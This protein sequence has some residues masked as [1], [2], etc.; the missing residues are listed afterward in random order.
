MSEIADWAACQHLWS[1]RR[2][3][4][5]PRTW[6]VYRL[7]REHVGALLTGSP[8]AMDTPV[9][10][11]SDIRHGRQACVV[12]DNII[13]QIRAHFDGIG[14]HMTGYYEREHR[15]FESVLGFTDDAVTIA[16][17]GMY[18][19]L[20]D[21]GQRPSW[22]AWLE[23]AD[24]ARDRECTHL[25]VIFAKVRKWPADP[26]VTFNTRPAGKIKAI[27]DEQETVKESLLDSGMPFDR[28]PGMHCIRCP[29]QQCP[30][31]A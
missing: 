23:V 10:W 5:A 20:L 16:D 27:N 24:I 8:V 21:I 2:G 7:I 19:W 18:W 3:R 11:S 14:H 28:T 15:A 26:E 25:G 30:V 12:G 6:S 1:L 4:P 9:K 22:T 17:E 31:R 13:G 29:D